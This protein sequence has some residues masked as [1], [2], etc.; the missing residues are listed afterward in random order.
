MADVDTV[1]PVFPDV[2]K[3]LAAADDAVARGDIE[4]ALAIWA[5]LRANFPQSPAAVVRAAALLVQRRRF[6]DAEPVLREGLE[7]FPGDIRVAAEYAQLASHRR[8]WPEALRRWQR[9]CERFPEHAPGYAAAAAALREMARYDEADALLADAIARFPGNVGLSTEYAVV[10]RQRRDW[11]E[12][13]RRWQLVCERF[14][15]QA[16]G[17]AGAAGALRQIGRLDEADAILADAVARFPA[18]QGL[19]AE[20]AGMARGRRRPHEALQRYETLR[21]R[22]PAGL[23]GYLGLASVLRELDRCEEAEAVLA[24]ASGRFPD[25]PAPAIEYA[26]LARIRRNWADALARCADLRARFPRHSSGYFMASMTHRE[27]GRL[28]EADDL[29]ADALGM[30]PGDPEIAIEYARIAL[31]RRDWPEAERRWGAVVQRFPNNVAGYGGL[32]A[33]LREAERFDEAEM[34]LQEASQRF[35]GELGPLIELAVLAHRRRDWPAAAERWARLRARDAGRIE[36][37]IRGAEA[38]REMRRF[39]EAEVVLREAMQAFPSQTQPFEAFAELAAWQDDW[40]AGLERW[41]DAYRRFPQDPRFVHHINIAR[42]RVL[43]IDPEAEALGLGSV[44]EQSAQ[45]TDP[46]DSPS[47]PALRDVA[48]HFESLGG[49]LYGCEFGTVQ[50]TFG[51]DPLG[52]LRWSDMPPDRLIAALEARFDGVGLPE[53]TVLAQY[54]SGEYGTRDTRFHMA[55]HTFVHSDQVP[56][57]KFTVQICRRLRLLARKL[58]EDLECANKIFVYKNTQRL[59]TAEE[60]DRLFAAVRGYAPA[61]LLFVQSETAEHPHGTVE[62]DR[63]GLLVGYIGGVPKLQSNGRME[64]VSA[65]W[66]PIVQRA[67][68]LWRA[69]AAGAPAEPRA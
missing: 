10:A 65:L 37:Y 54:P 12:T 34:L 63:P 66:V 32:A 56:A 23:V 9:V 27:A 38:L 49:F 6:A 3:G 7:R 30:F 68:A 18:D 41:T 29:M 55:M 69:D 46:A 26:A 31:A 44:A 15:Q 57:D 36:G 22:F 45:P 64:D 16:Y 13:F 60:L 35:A 20:Y 5:G 59:L 1:L 17:Y 21:E 39:E 58:V 43:D 47:A 4:A 14:P 33:V 28:D 8:D 19:A 40:K 2:G 52:L 61:T 24:E 42:L 11:P 67:Y 50:R 62:R 51:A 25:E 48:A 53:N